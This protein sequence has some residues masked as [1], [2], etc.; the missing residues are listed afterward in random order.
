MGHHCRV[1]VPGSGK[2]NGSFLDN[3]VFADRAMFINSI[4]SGQVAVLRPL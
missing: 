3:L 2:F 1:A 4:A